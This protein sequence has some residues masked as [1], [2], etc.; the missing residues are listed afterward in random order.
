MKRFLLNILVFFIPICLLIFPPFALLILSK[1]GYYDLDKAI[2][3][4]KKLVVGYAYE[5]S[6][7]AYL[8]WKTIKQQKRSD[9]IALGSSRVLQFR[10]DMFDGSFYNAGFAI[11]SIRDLKP[12]LQSIPA[13]KYSQYLI[14]GLDQWMFNKSWDDLKYEQDDQAWTQYVKYP[15]ATVYKQVYADL[16]S[17]KINLH[18]LLKKDSLARIG[19]NAW[20]NNRG[21][22]SDGSMNY[23][24][25]LDKLIRKDSTVNDFGYSDTYD[26]INKGTG[27]FQF[28]D[29][30]NMEAVMVLEDLLKFCAA[31]NIYVIS[32]L[33]P[34]ADKVYKKMVESGKFGYLNQIY[35][36][37]APVFKKYGFEIYDFSTMALANSSD[38]ETIDGFHGSEVAYLRLLIKMLESG[39]ELSRFA[40]LEKL[41]RDILHKQNNF[42][43]YKY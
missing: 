16:F 19:L 36:T 20:V 10:E 26:R 40:N 5:E 27:R 41:R 2:A 22:R 25:T 37:L 9:I 35:P 21:Y 12:F 31:N 17:G 14:I 34:F 13:T 3:T 15:A 18:S 32:I 8:K 7:Y 43:V 33:P 1:E 39:S 28:A 6:K 29:N 11:S 4:D 24:N 23:G 30:M 38:A 42:V